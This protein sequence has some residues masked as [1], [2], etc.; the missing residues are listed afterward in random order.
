MP[1]CLER[2]VPALECNPEVSLVCGGRYSINEN[3]QIFA[4]KRYSAKQKTIPGHKVISRC[5]FGGNYIGE[6]TGVIFRKADVQSGFRDDLPQLMDMELWFKLLELGA[7]LSIETP[8]CL[9]RHHDGQMTQKNIRSGKLIED[10]ISLLNEFSVKSYLK[11]TPFLSKKHKLRMT[12]RIW[13]SRRFLDQAK[14]TELLRKYGLRFLY[15][16]MAIIFL[17]LSLKINVA[18]VNGNK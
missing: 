4:F 13:L 16:F 11:I 3:G 9:V 14:R 12:Y 15:P 8:V 10:N 1:E 5:L 6:P 2:M 7:L 17:V 18:G